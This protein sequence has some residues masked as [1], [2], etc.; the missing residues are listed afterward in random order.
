[1]VDGWP[2]LLVMAKGE[3]GE[4]DVGRTW[5]DSQGPVRDHAN[6][7]HDAGAAQIDTIRRVGMTGLCRWRWGGRARGKRARGTLLG[8]FFSAL[9]D[10]LLRLHVRGQPAFPCHGASAS[11]PAGAVATATAVRVSISAPAGARRRAPEPAVA[12]GVR[13]APGARAGAR[14]R[15]CAHAR[16]RARRPEAELAGGREGGELE[17]ARERVARVARLSERVWVCV[18]E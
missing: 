10:H 2:W 3:I 12:I 1:M 6:T 7:S 11:T 4:T 15:T 5:Q 9:D 18:R 8:D 17:I 14:A 16:F 13:A